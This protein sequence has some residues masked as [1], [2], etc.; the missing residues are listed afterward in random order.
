MKATTR[1]LPL[2]ALLATTATQPFSAQVAGAAPSI[3][4]NVL[5][6]HAETNQPLY[7]TAS[8]PDGTVS[9]I[10]VRLMEKAP[11]AAS[12]SMVWQKSVFGQ[13]QFVIGDSP[14]ATLQV[15]AAA[16]KG[17]VIQHGSRVCPVLE[18]H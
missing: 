3:H 11:D 15:N 16:K 18:S 1:F 10:R 5:R 4:F 8:D 17:G 2:L 12:Y 13:E 6:L 7:I 9:E 14:L